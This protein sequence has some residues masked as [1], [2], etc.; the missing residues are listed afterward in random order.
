[1]KGVH[2]H[3]HVCSLASSPSVR[4]KGSPGTHCACIRRCH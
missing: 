1:M 3:V 4:R 2:V